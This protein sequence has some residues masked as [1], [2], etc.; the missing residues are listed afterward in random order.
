MPPKTKSRKKPIEK[1]PKIVELSDPSEIK[2]YDIPQETLYEQIERL[3]REKD[4]K[5][6]QKKQENNGK[7]LPPP[8]QDPELGIMGR[9]MFA[10][11]DYTAYLIPLLSANVTLNILVRMQ[12][13]QQLDPDLIVKELISTIPVL[14]ILFK[15]FHPYKSHL[16]F[17][18]ASFISSVAIGA[19][20]L[21]VTNEEGYYYVMKRT[22]PLGTVWV[23]MFIEMEWN[24]SAISLL[25]IGLYMYI[26]DYRF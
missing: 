16:W 19:Y 22:P 24:W 2:N 21:F 26:R 25:V 17:K 1:N 18:I 13:G 5:E 3:N 6:F 10:I 7:N 11:L 14:I 15:F 9:A 4:L 8:D 20:L 12:Y 23:W